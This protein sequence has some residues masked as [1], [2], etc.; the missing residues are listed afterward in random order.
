MIRNIVHFVQAQAATPKEI[1]LD[2]LN[3][4]TVFLDLQKGLYSN[5]LMKFKLNDS[6]HDK[7]FLFMPMEVERNLFGKGFGFKRRRHTSNLVSQG[8]FLMET[9]FLILI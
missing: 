6:F 5:V 9:G 7:S 1:S 3:N 4:D 2:C 8:E